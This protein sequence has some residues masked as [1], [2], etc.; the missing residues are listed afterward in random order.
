MEN[1]KSCLIHIGALVL[2][3]LI[4]LALFFT[5]RGSSNRTAPEI[6]KNLEDG[7]LLISI[8]LFDV[9]SLEYA[10]LKGQGL[11]FEEIENRPKNLHTKI[12]I[13]IV[14]LLVVIQ[15]VLMIIY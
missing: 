2:M 9:H 4:I 1:K 6:I 8:L 3:N 11:S 13:G 7:V 15:I 10:Y 5:L 12:I 14:F